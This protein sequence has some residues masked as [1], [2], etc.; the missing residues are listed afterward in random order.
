MLVSYFELPPW[1]LGLLMATLLSPLAFAGAGDRGEGGGDDLAAFSEWVEAY[2][3]AGDEARSQMVPEGKRLAEKRQ[4]ILA[5]LMEKKPKEAAKVMVAAARREKLPASVREHLEEP[6]Q[7]EGSLQV[8]VLD[9][10]KRG[11]SRHDHSLTVEGV[12][13]RAFLAV[14]TGP[15][16]I[17][18]P[19][20]I[21]G[22]RL[23]GRILLTTATSDR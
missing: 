23:D 22:F 11:V 3:S 12:R 6:I 14:D 20:R 16:P 7:G 15:V 5:T 13:Y 17:N 8:V 1:L 2:L 10:F 9:D 18:Q 21:E 4:P 19:L